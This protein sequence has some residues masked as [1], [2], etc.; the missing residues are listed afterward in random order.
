MDYKVFVTSRAELD[1]AECLYY[2]LYEKDSRQA[3][4]SILADY[5]DTL[6]RLKTVA[7]SLKICDNPKLSLLGYRRINFTHHNYL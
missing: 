7:D 2:L 6:E 5:E 1:I 4:Q 3:A